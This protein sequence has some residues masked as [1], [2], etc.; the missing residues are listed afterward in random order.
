[1][2]VAANTCRWFEDRQKHVVAVT[3]EEKRRKC[4]ALDGII[5]NLN[6]KGVVISILCTVHAKAMYNDQLPFITGEY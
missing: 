1:M 6:R 2:S 3:T 5:G 4:C